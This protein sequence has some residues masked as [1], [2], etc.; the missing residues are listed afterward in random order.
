MA[1]RVVSA[2]GADDDLAKRSRGLP[3]LASCWRRLQSPLAIGEVSWT[4]GVNSHAERLPTSVLR[5]I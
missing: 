4:F 5:S 3:L 2:K 1:Q